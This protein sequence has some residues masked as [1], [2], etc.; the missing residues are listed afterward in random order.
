MYIPYLN[1]TEENYKEYKNENN[2]IELSNVN[3][4]IGKNN[5]GKSRL[6]REILIAE[7]NNKYYSNSNYKD[8]EKLNNAIKKLLI[9]AN[10]NDLVEN[11]YKKTYLFKKKNPSYRRASDEAEL[12]TFI[13]NIL[14]PNSLYNDIYKKAVD[15]KILKVTYG[16]GF[17]PNHSFQ[18]AG[19][20]A[21]LLQIRNEIAEYYDL[22]LSNI[23]SCVPE[24]LFFP[25]LLSLR[26]LNNLDE[27]EPSYHSKLAEMFANE[28]FSKLKNF[29]NNIKT[30]QE[31]YDDM[32]KQ[33]LGL[34]TDRKRFLDYEKYIS[35]NFFNDKE[36]SIF[37]KDDD[38]NIYVKEGEEK[39]YPIY[40]LGDGLQTL[41]TITY[42]LFM[43]SSKPMKIFI[44]EPEIH[45]HPG[46]QRVFISKLQDYNN[47]QFFITT[48]SSNLIDICDEY[49][50]NT[51]IICVEKTEDQKKIYNS[52]YDDMD[53]YTLLGTRPSSI[54]LSNCTI[55]VEGP[56]D[57]YYIESILQLYCDINNKKKY[58]LGYNYNYA[59]NGSIN[60]AS[61]IDF[62]D[63]SEN[64]TMKI[65]RLS[66][67]NFIIFDSDNLDP[68]S[69]NYK[70][71]QKLKQK[72]GDNCYVIKKLKTIENIINPKILQD[73][74]EINYNPK[75]KWKKIEV[76]NFF[77]KLKAKYGEK[78]YFSMNIAKELAQYLKKNEP[79]N[80]KI[81]KQTLDYYNKSI[82]NFWKANKYSLSIFFYNTINQLK[83]EE[84][85]HIY[86]TMMH[87]FIIM[88]EK[89]YNFIK[90]N[91]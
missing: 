13:C 3:V 31:I 82:N 81:K 80:E 49:D 75:Q 36:I 51:S 18:I 59:F 24:T 19:G 73:Y 89:I 77:E 41:L 54:I 65:N 84:K 37:I 6:M 5:S 83:H 7:Y 23:E 15:K 28:Y 40:M 60:I 64:I 22:I 43:N 56:T 2:I 62:D 4:F 61:K 66:K 20:G 26:K 29:H 47:C 34:N 16:Q 44:D 42:Y 67:K 11:E 12:A 90:S 39:E 8:F 74:F 50:E 25:S 76:T 55:W 48:H 58:K 79:K 85:K 57:I 35:K 45:L 72:M 52:E 46:L 1:L 70:K 63:K 10:A 14:Y 86:D 21:F 78:D 91:N 17:T 53:L 68:E 9:K 88:I 30:G 87:E 69:A 71:I 38:H 33:L 32:K 27:N